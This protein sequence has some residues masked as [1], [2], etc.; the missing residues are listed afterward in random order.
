MDFI[1]PMKV[2]SLGGKCYVFVCVDDYSRF[3]SVMFIK[4][5]S[6]TFEQFKTLYLKI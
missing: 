2:E 6:D 1:G 5:K 4:D 3:T